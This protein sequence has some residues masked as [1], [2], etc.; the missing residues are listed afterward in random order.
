MTGLIP[1]NW[2]NDKSRRECTF[3]SSRAR[4]AERESMIV[5]NET[6]LESRVQGAL[7]N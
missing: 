6:R 7:S 4:S 2:L 5:S 1:L 3:V